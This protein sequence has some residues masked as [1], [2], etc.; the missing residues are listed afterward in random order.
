MES[1]TLKTSIKKLSLL[2][3]IHLLAILLINLTCATKAK[4]D[5]EQI[6]LK[7]SVAAPFTG[8]LVPEAIY[9]EMQV[10][11]LKTQSLEYE[12]SACIEESEPNTYG[13][14]HWAFIGL[15]V[16][17]LSGFLL[18]SYVSGGR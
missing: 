8:V 18:N 9:R 12:L 17:L 10:D 11:I 1:S 15:G 13:R 4:G 5:Q 16:G 14:M 7:E 2:L 3:R 6:I